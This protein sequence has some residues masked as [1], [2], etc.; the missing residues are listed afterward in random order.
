[1]I[2][3]GASVILALMLAASCGATGRAAASPSHATATVASPSATPLI[4]V[5]DMMGAFPPATFFVSAKD[6]VKAIAL[7]NHA[8]RYTIPT[9]GTDVQVAAASAQTG[10]PTTARAP[11]SAGSTSIAAPNVRRGR[12]RARR[13]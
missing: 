11:G 4:D 9:S 8:T 6:G 12:S 2:A 1:M 3:R 10:V 13:S 7:L 5:N